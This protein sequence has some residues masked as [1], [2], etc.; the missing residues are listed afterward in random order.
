MIAHNDDIT[1]HHTLADHFSLLYI[2]IRDFMYHGTVSY[3]CFLICA[4]DK[5][6][7][8]EEIHVASSRYSNE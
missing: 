6:A 2:I 3:G 4:D 7:S 8:L 5:N 1:L